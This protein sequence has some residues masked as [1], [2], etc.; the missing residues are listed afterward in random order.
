ME[1]GLR[2]KLHP[3]T[4]NNGRTYMPAAC[5]TMSNDDKNTFS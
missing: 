2:H 5:Y 4:A 3:F 1:M